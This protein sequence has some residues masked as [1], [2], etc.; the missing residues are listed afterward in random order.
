MDNRSLQRQLE[1]VVVFQLLIVCLLSALSFGR[2]YACESFP[3]ISS[4]AVVGALLLIS[5]FLRLL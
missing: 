4:F 1:A 3:G 2:S 5:Y